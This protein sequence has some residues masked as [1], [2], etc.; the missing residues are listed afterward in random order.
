MFL[1]CSSK[2]KLLILKITALKSE[3]LFNL[4]SAQNWVYYV[5]KLHNFTKPC[6]FSKVEILNINLNLN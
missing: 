1:K 4:L 6:F 5:L 2:N 3:D